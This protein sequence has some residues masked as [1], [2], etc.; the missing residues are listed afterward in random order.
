MPRTSIVQQPG[1]EF[2]ARACFSRN[3]YG[4]TRGRRLLNQSPQIPHGMAAADKAILAHGGGQLCFQVSP[5]LEHLMFASHHD[6]RAFDLGEIER[7]VEIVERTT[8]H[9]LDG[10][11]RVLVGG[12]DRDEAVGVALVQCLDEP[13]TVG[14]KAD[15]GRVKSLVSRSSKRVGIGRYDGIGMSPLLEMEVELLFFV[16][17]VKEAHRIVQILNTYV[18]LLL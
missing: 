12:N 18:Q 5:L 3:E 10:H 8:F 14:M 9:R 7:R 15:K 17:V 2:F 6:S 1:D 11:A 4:R 16:V 13:K